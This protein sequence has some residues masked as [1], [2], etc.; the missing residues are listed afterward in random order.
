MIRWS[1]LKGLTAL[2]LF[3]VLAAVIEYLIVVY[4]ISIGVR[5]ETSFQIPW[6]GF[7]VS[8]LFH[9][10]PISTVVVLAASWTY[11]VKY[12]AMKPSEKPR[13]T[14]KKAKAAGKKDTGLKA[15][16]SS[17]LGKIKAK[18]LKVKGVAY[19]WKRISFAKTTMKS[20]VVIL[21]VFLAS[22]L[23]VSVL[24]NPWLVYK[25]FSTLYQNSPHILEFVMTTNNALQGF[26]E[27][28]T[29]IGWICSYIDNAIR[30]AAPSFIN[31]ASTLGALTKPLVDL[32]PVA[33][34]LVFQ[35]LAAWVSALA[36]LG[37]GAYTRKGYR[38]KRIKKV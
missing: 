5:D 28:A 34:Y 22:A 4:A 3:I 16:I 8:P 33:K 36:V 9:L 26:A 13:Q 23:L 31:F 15:R 7:T 12:A 1:T 10:V 25:T 20:A 2:I 35:N 38:Y 32:P 24:A 19:L 17:F 18:L 29:P 21:L 30:A 11:M 14:P 27:A 6:L 37:Y